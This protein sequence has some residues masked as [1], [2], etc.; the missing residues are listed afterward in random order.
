MTKLIAIATLV[1]SMSASAGFFD[2]FGDGS[3]KDNGIFGM[4]HNEMW[5]PRWYVKEADNF[6]N[7]LDGTNNKHDHN[8]PAQYEQGN[9]TSYK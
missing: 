3:Y 7:E 6:L 9:Q 2:N 5:E 8:F 4:N 1:A